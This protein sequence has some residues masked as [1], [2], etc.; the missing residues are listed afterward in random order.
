MNLQSLQVSSNPIVL[1]LKLLRV[2][3]TEEQ[4]FNANTERFFLKTGTLSPKRMMLCW[5]KHIITSDAV[6]WA[7]WS[8]SAA[9][10][11]EWLQYYFSVL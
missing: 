11:P 8:T 10:E 5:L 9:K 1:I 7:N 4:T 3:E 2:N 6:H